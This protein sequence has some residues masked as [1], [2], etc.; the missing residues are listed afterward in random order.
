[1]K[2]DKNCM[3]KINRLIEIYRKNARLVVGLISG[4]LV[5]SV[6]AV[7]VKLRSSGLGK[8]N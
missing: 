6:G 5:D 2:I 4:T 7:L 1:M 8:L 3:D